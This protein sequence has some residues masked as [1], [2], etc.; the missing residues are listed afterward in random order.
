MRAFTQVLFVALL[1]VMVIPSC[2]T[3]PFLITVEARPATAKKPAKPPIQIASLGF[4]ILTK[5]KEETASMELPGGIKMSHS[6][7]GKNEVS[8]PNTLITSQA[9]EAMSA[10][11]AGVANTTTKA[12]VDKAQISATQAV[13]IQQSRAAVEISKHAV[14]AAPAP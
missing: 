5:S 11:S 6:I 12:G 4:S 10:I 1:S 9:L 13:E 8:V 14:E 2:S 7:S 3:K